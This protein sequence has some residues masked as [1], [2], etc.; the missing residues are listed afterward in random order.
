[1][2]AAAL[3]HM[4][5]R[6]GRKPTSAQR[7]GGEL[8]LDTDTL[9]GDKAFH[10]FRI[11]LCARIFTS[12]FSLVSPDAGKPCCRADAIFSAAVCAYAIWLRKN[13][14]ALSHAIFR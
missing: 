14:A 11:D 2:T 13:G 3:P 1:M 10:A 5:E 8:P 12:G 6:G 4:K 7:R 9:I